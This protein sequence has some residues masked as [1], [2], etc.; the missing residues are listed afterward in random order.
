VQQ[1]RS[2]SVGAA[3]ARALAGTGVVVDLSL[4]QATTEDL[5]FTVVALLDGEPSDRGV[6]PVAIT[7]DHAQRIRL[8]LCDSAGNRR[9]VILDLTTP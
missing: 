2:R 6:R 4:R 9:E 8:V 7:K 1:L 5:T 3:T